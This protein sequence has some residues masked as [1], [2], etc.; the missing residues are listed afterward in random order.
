[1]ITA[2]SFHAPA[3]RVWD[4]L[5]DEGKTAIL[6]GLPQ[7]HPPLPHRG[8]TVA[9]FP[10][11][12]GDTLFTF[13]EEIAQDAH[14]AAGGEYIIDVK[15]FRTDEKDR[16]LGQL[17][18]MA[19]SRFRVAADLLIHKPWDFF[20]MVEIAPDRMHHAFWRFSA[21]D[22]PLYE[23]GNPYERVI[24]DFYRYLDAW[25]GSLMARLGDETTLM[26]ISDHGCRSLLGS[27]GINEWLIQK[28]YLVL[29]DEPME[30]T[31]LRPEMID[32]KR[33]KAWGE[34]GYYARVF[35]NL[36]GRE[37]QGIVDPFEYDSFREDLA[38]LIRGIQDE[39]GRA[40]QNRVLKPEKIYRTC[41]NVPPDLMVYFDNLNRR[42]VGTVGAGRVLGS[43]N[44][45]GP[46]DANH[47]PEGVLIITRMDDLRK[48]IKRNSKID[49]TSLLDITPTIL[50]EFGL[51]VP[52]QLAGKIIQTGDSGSARF[53]SHVSPATEHRT[54]PISP[55]GYSEEEEET[56]RK[57]LADL[58]YI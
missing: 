43:G 36:K 26:V 20:M 10:V 42:S 45:T 18:A 32:W 22:H 39:N 28:G 31:Q 4:Y 38:E 8:I 40:L 49:S 5:E 6:L 51:P 48:G 19:E 58:G 27:V 54:C 41:N 37:P 35:I 33:T 50:H 12:D 25:M 3:R 17:Y 57:H 21:P 30:E 56:I 55:A 1:M 2:N 29:L 13:P 53:S 52:G 15:D 9:G 44:D 24:P 47:D 46:D 34:G 16:L 11:P 14:L 23:S 7:T